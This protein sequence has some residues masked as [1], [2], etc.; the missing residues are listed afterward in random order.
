MIDQS[1]CWK[2]KIRNSP[3]TLS[4]SLTCNRPLLLHVLPSAHARLNKA[5][6]L[7]SSKLSR[8]HEMEGSCPTYFIGYCTSHARPMAIRSRPNNN[9]T[10][11]SLCL[12]HAAMLHAAMH[13]LIT[14]PWFIPQRMPPA[15]QH[16]ADTKLDCTPSCCLGVQ[17]THTAVN[18][19]NRSSTQLQ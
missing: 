10:P 12:M 19:G 9:A 6:P 15:T 5:K 3:D 14:S 11:F 4:M 13:S 17:R 1:S 7:A 18:P 16:K 8:S 2:T